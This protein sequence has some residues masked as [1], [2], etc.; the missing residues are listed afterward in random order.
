MA[1]HARDIESND[2]RASPE[3]EEDPPDSVRIRRVSFDAPAPISGDG[4]SPVSR[5]R[6]VSR[7]LATRE[8]SDEEGAVA[9]MT[10]AP[11]ARALTPEPMSPSRRALSTLV[12]SGL[13][14]D[15][16]PLPIRE[17]GESRERSDSA[18]SNEW[19][20]AASHSLE[21]GRA[22]SVSEAEAQVQAAAQRLSAADLAGAGRA[23]SGRI[24]FVHESRSQRLRSASRD[25]YSP[26]GSMGGAN[27][28][29]DTQPVAGGTRVFAARKATHAAANAPGGVSSQPLDIASASGSATHQRLLASLA[30]CR[31]TLPASAQAAPTR[32]AV[33]RRQDGTSAQ[34]LQAA[35][36]LQRRYHQLKVATAEQP[37]CDRPLTAM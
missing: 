23:A 3:P 5:A 24:S 35:R 34:A 28:A 31:S 11:A 36:T 9:L 21:R 27:A 17:R 6:R 29:A 7:D 10:L 20:R 4:L 15:G 19:A 12:A 22:A 26:A 8:L 2:S 33:Y 32:I 25:R 30:A 1:A 18:A 37:P 16:M 14:A 13:T